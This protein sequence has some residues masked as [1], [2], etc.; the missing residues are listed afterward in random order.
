MTPAVVLDTMST[1]SSMD[2][3]GPSVGPVLAT[4]KRT[5]DATSDRILVVGSMEAAQT[6]Q[7][8]QAVEQA[9]MGGVRQVEMHMVDRLTDGATTLERDTFPEIF[10]LSPWSNEASQ[11]LAPLSEAL[12]GDGKL[13]ITIVASAGDSKQVLT[14]VHLALAGAGFND[15]QENEAALTVSAKKTSPSIQASALPLRRK[16]GK[17]ASSE[18]KALWNVAGKDTPLIDQN[19]ILTDA[20]KKLPSAARR[21][22]CD[23]EKALTNGR[24]KKACKGCTCGL[25]ELEEEEELE[26][27]NSLRQDVVKLDDN[28]MDLPNNSNGPSKSE[29]T[30]TMVDENGMTRVIKRI[31]VDTKGATSSCGSCFLGD[32][33]R[34]SSCPYLGK[35]NVREILRFSNTFFQ[36]YLRS[37]QEKKWK[38][39]LPWM[40]TFKS[41]SSL[42][43]IGHHTNIYLHF[44][45]LTTWHFLRCDLFLLFC[46]M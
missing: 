17:G 35:N 22:D 29:V 7:Y 38:F 18:K 34:C 19:S 45:I 36:V 24:K 43:L 39:Q 40:T 26:R 5:G 16:L 3:D 4:S 12:R 1:S 33:F 30:E 10:L 11:I 27:M 31:R 23:L 14:Q 44:S 9:G 46:Y 15:I 32:A 6:G 21:D 8:Q 41:H 13:N 28:D 20:E 42:L 25:R 2:V 37:S